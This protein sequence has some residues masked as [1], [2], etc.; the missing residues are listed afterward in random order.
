MTA[1]VSHLVSRKTSM[2]MNGLVVECFPSTK[3]VLGLILS[4]GKEGW[5]G[6]KMDQEGKRKVIKALHCL[7]RH[8][9]RSK[10]LRRLRPFPKQKLS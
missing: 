5:K 1:C 6:E 2:W 10:H 8:N 7:E 3:E 4:T 9:G